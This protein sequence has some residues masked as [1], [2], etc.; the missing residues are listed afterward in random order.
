MRLKTVGLIMT[1]AIG[2]LAAPLEA[3]AQQA[4]RAYR[5]GVLLAAPAATVGTSIQ[6]LREGLR[7][8]GYVEGQNLTLELKSVNTAVGELDRLAAD[9]VR[10]KIDVLVTWTT[11]STLAAMRATSTIPIVMV[12]VGDPLGSRLV[13]S[14]ARPGGNVTGVSNVQRDLSG[15][16]LELL[17]EVRP[18]ATRIAALRNPT[19]PA[20]ELAWRETRTAAQS[21]GIQLQLAQMHEPG[22]LEAAF[23]AIVRAHASGVVV[24]AD[25][26]FLAERNRIAEL[27]RKARLPTVFQRAENVEAGGLISYGPKLSEQFRQAASYV[28]KILRGAKP[29]DLPVEQPTKFELVINRKTAKALG[30][31]IPPSLLVRADRV[32]E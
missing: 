24:I 3:E 12:S 14:L 5:I 4:T 21:L 13:A 2:N 10:T 9:L 20:S 31:T 8:L 29:A 27:A 28:D 30:L 32:I 17:R 23:A 25:P 22:E 11:P 6:A 7:E 26:L 19:N 16:Q 1:L 15:K 18:G